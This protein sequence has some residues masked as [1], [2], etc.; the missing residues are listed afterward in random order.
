MLVSMFFLLLAWKYWIP[1]GGF[2]CAEIPRLCSKRILQSVTPQYNV[3]VN[4]KP[5]NISRAKRSLAQNFWQQTVLE[6]LD[7]TNVSDCIICTPL[8]QSVTQAPVILEPVPLDEFLGKLGC[9]NNDKF[10]GN[11]FVN[12]RCNET[13]YATTSSHDLLVVPVPDN[14]RPFYCLITNNSVAFAE[15]CN[16]SYNVQNTSWHINKGTVIPP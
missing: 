4:V 15:T 13:W 12:V 5:L 2:D 7:L 1:L 16:M 6:I 14:F 3:S 8:P 10:M 11:C 9:W